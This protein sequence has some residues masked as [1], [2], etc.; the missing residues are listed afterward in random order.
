MTLFPVYPL[1]DINIVKGKGCHVWDDKGQEYLDL[2]G[3]HAVIS[4]GHCH[5]HYVDMLTKQLNT[6]GFYSNSVINTLQS[7]LAERL[8]QVCGYPDYQLFLINSGAE[9]NENA[10]K[11]AS[12]HT[13]RKR[14][15]AA[16]KAFHGRTSL[17]VE[18]TDN[19]KIV[20]PVNSNGHVTFLPLN[21]LAAFEAEL[22]K[23]D[24]AAVIVECIQGVGGI[25]MATA[26]FMQG[27]RKACDKTGTVLICDEIQ[28][29]YGRSGKFFAH[30]HLG[31]KPDIITCAKGIG[32]GFPMGAVIISPKFEA[33]YGMLGTTFGGNHLACTAALAV[34]DVIEHE[35]LVDNAAK[36]G[37]YL[38]EE[39][40]KLQQTDA[41]IVD[42][43]G[44]GLMIGIEYDQP[45]KALRNALVHDEHVFTGAASTNILRLLPPLTLSLDEAKLAVEHI[46]QVSKVLG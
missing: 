10:L 22:N 19:P 40:K 23:G 18:A 5:P 36:V 44:E 38:M 15:L 28:C 30:Q 2:Y 6:L 14:V 9:A 43:R 45:I 33:V 7:Q 39:L 46:K 37:A 35:Q 8:G 17:A 27:L 21:D 32:N 20:A 4:I 29:G 26:D 11:L 41:H 25:R 16:G 24:V 34:L 3:G 1:F 31:V 12:F 13:G 42:V